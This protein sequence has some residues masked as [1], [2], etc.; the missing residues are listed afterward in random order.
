MSRNSR[1]SRKRRTDA[2]TKSRKHPDERRTERV[3]EH[4]PE[5]MTMEEAKGEIEQEKA[6]DGAKGCGCERQ[7]GAGTSTSKNAEVE[8]PGRIKIVLTVRTER[9]VGVDTKKKSSATPIIYGICLLVVLFVALHSATVY[10]Y[11][12]SWLIGERLRNL[13]RFLLSLT[14]CPR[15]WFQVR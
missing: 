8:R 4:D 1:P 7:A 12:L 5:Q 2:P 6:K 14:S 3:D 13:H 10:E 11:V 15:G 9:S